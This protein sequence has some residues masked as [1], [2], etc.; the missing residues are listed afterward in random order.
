MTPLRFFPWHGAVRAVVTDAGGM[1]WRML[2]MNGEA[3]GVNCTVL[4]A[5]IASCV[6]VGVTLS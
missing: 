2:T 4:D 6:W 3:H 5:Y 1:L